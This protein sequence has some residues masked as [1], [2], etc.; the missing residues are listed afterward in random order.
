MIATVVSE[1]WKKLALNICTLPTAALLRFS[2]GQ[3]IEHEPL[4]ELMKALLRETTEVANA[5]HI[6][7]DF[8]ERWDAIS[9]LLGRVGKAKPSMLQDVEA[10]RRTEID[11]INGAIVTAGQEVGVPTPRNETM[12][13]L[14]RSQEATFAR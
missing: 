6:A 3:L 5:K 9:S 8:D 2:A 14:I 7:L 13:Q 4:V 11:V 12:V 10:G 1:I